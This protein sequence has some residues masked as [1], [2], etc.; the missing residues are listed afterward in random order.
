M[1]NL[2]SMDLVF[3]SIYNEDAEPQI[4][5]SFVYLIYISDWFRYPEEGNVNSINYILGTLHR[6]DIFCAQY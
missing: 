4:L 3:L 1:A 6:E 2:I 5:R